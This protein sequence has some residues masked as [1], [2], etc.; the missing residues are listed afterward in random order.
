MVSKFLK[1]IS[2]NKCN[3][4]EKIS[5]TTIKIILESVKIIPETGSGIILILVYEIFPMGKRWVNHKEVSWTYKKFEGIFEFSTKIL[6][7][8]VTKI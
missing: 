8:N 3:P 4:L 6:F 7:S 5:K 1:L 2:I